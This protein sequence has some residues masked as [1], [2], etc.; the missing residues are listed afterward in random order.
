[1]TRD[2]QIAGEVLVA[3]AAGEPLDRLRV[4]ATAVQELHRLPAQLVPELQALAR[5]RLQIVRRGAGGEGPGVGVTERLGEILELVD[6]GE[7]EVRQLL[8]DPG[9]DGPELRQRPEHGGDGGGD[10]EMAGPQV[11]GRDARDA[12]GQAG[13]PRPPPAAASPRKVPAPEVEDR[14]A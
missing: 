5:Q 14:P 3:V 11:V 1:V 8:H 12:G 4:E 2:L 7:L 10:V 9:A 6:V 13:P